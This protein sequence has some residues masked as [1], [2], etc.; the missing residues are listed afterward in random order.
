MAYAVRFNVVGGGV[1]YAGKA[2]PGSDISAAV[3][4]IR[5]IVETAGDVQVLFADGSEEF[6]KKWTDHLSL[7]Y[8]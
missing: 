4:Q 3:W 1:S 7:S 5:K 2:V 6:N 8:S